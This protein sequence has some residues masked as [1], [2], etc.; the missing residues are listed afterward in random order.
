MNS[1]VDGLVN[2]MCYLISHIPRLDMHLDNV[3][4]SIHQICIQV[5]GL[6][7]RLYDVEDNIRVQKSQVDIIQDTIDRHDDILV[8]KQYYAF[9]FL[10]SKR[11]EGYFVGQ[12]ATKI[13]I[14]VSGE[15]E[16]IEGNSDASLEEN[17]RDQ[18]MNS[19][20]SST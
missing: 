15:Q 3:E 17:S 8:V 20:N 5:T 4:Q 1:Y 7:I 19:F 9:Y 12:H 16:N 18:V 6:D 13:N 10:G 2:S 14:S 11:T